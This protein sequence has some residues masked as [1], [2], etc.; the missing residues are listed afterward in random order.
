MRITLRISKPGAFFAFLSV[1]LILT[2]CLTLA[3]GVDTLASKAISQGFLTSTQ[4][5]AFAAAAKAAELAANPLT[6]QETYYIGR[7]VAARIFT[8][9]HPYGCAELIS[10]LNMLGQGLALYSSKPEIYAGYHFMALDSTEVNAFASPGGHVLVTRGMLRLARSE[11]ELAAVLAHEIS[12]IALGHGLKSVQGSRLTQIASDFAIQAG[13]SGGSDA[14]AFTSAFGDSIAELAS[15]LVISGYSLSYELEADQEAR[16]MLLASGYDPRALETLI[17]RLPRGGEASAAGFALTHPD[18]ESRLDALR[19]APSEGNLAKNA[20]KYRILQ[21]NRD[22]DIFKNRGEK[23]SPAS[24]RAER[25]EA[26][27]ILF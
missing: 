14:A 6:P 24:V 20:A 2:S 10:Y 8:S 1:F 9:Y 21:P 4:A 25:F 13:M 26:A 17:S 12:H 27:R 16:R 11:D 22:S 5:A 18:A 3:E 7:A 23:I 19:R 15:S